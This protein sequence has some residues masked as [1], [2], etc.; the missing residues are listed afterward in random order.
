MPWPLSDR[1]NRK[2]SRLIR[3]IARINSLQNSKFIKTDAMLGITHFGKIDVN[4][5]KAV[6]LYNPS[7]LTEIMMHPMCIEETQ[8]SQIKFAY[9]R[10]IEF[11]TLCSE[12]TKQLLEDANMKLINY[13][14]L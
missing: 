8:Q 12:R 5:F 4:F 2:K 3:S 1:K 13:G 7:G 11:E 9:Q 6:S 14:Q 10:R